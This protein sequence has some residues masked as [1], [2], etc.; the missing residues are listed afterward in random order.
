MKYLAIQKVEIF[1]ILQF[2]FFLFY[3]KISYAHVDVLR[4]LDFLAF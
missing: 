2:H 3:F 1:L 4:Y